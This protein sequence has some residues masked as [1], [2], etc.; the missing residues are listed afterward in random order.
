MECGKE[1]SPYKCP[2]CLSC[3]CSLSCSRLH[4]EKCGRIEAGKTSEASTKDPLE[5]STKEPK[6][7]PLEDN[8]KIKD[9]LERN[10]Y[11]KTH[12]PIL[13]A[14]ITRSHAQIDSKVDSSL[15][16]DLERQSRTCEILKETLEVD[17]NVLEL[18]S[19]LQSEGYL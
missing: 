11:L 10:P 2:Q 18:Y 4:K 6:D 19:L 12:L 7:V 15:A 1:D 13:L 8:V 9:L 3:Y 16:K 14:R 17:P 5:P